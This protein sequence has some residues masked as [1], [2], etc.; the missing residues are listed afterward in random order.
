[1]GW[2]GIGK[3]KKSDLEESLVQSN[4]SVKELKRPK[5]SKK[6]KK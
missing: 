3:K 6:A 4:E 5:K 2:F 1:M